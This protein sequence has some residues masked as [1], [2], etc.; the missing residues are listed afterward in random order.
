MTN[1]RLLLKGRETYLHD[2]DG[3]AAKVLR[4]TVF[5]YVTPVVEGCAGRRI[6]L[7]EAVAGTL[8]PSYHYNS[9]DE[10]QGFL[11]VPDNEAEIELVT[12]EDAAS[13]QRD[14]LKLAGVPA[15]ESGFEEC[16]NEQ[17][18]LIVMQ[19]EI[20]FLA[21]NKE[22]STAAQRG[23][24][25][26]F[27]LFHRENHW[28]YSTNTKSDLYNAMYFM[29][30]YMKIDIVPYH[31]L[32]ETCGYSFKAT[33]I[34]RLSHFVIREITLENDW[35]QTDA[36]PVLA[37][38]DRSKKPVVCVPRAPGRYD[39]YGVK[40]SRRKVDAKLAAGF[41]PSAYMIYQPFPNEPLKTRDV[42]KF[43][44]S[45]VYAGDLISYAALALLGSIIGLL[46]PY[47]N[48]LIFDQFIPMSNQAALIEICA[49][50]LAC[51]LGN[52]AFSLVKNLSM[53]RGTRSMEYAV[54]A[55][56]FD[57]LF[58]MPQSFFEQYSSADLVG[59]V[60]GISQIYR[61]VSQ[62]ALTTGLGSLFSILYLVRLFRSSSKLA[63]AAIF[64][65]LFAMAVVAV[66]GTLKLKYE[67]KRLEDETAAATMMYQLLSGIQ[68][69]RLS[70]VENHALY[71]YLKPYIESRRSDMKTGRLEN[72]GATF[73]SAVSI[74]FSMVLYFI[75]I[76]SKVEISIGSFVAFSSAFGM[77]SASMM[78]L[79][80]CYL[81]VNMIIPNYKRVKP[82][83]E[84]TKELVENAAMPRDVTGNIEVS[85]LEF[86]YGK[87]EP[88][89]LKG[90][91]FEIKRGEYVGIVG[92]SGCGKSTLLKCLLGF[93]KPSAG[94]VY[95]DG[96]DVEALDKRE[97]RKHF[98]VVLQDGKLIG[99]SILEN[100]SIANP[101]I[102]RDEVKKIIVDVG[103]EDEI[104]RMPMGLETVLSENTGT[105]SGGQMQRILIGRAIANDPAI[106]FFDEATSALDNV[107]QMK[108]CENLEKRNI[109]RV[110]IAHRLST[111]ENCD[112]ILVMHEGEIVET[113]TFKELMDR[114]GLFYELA[115]RQIV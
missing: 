91:S 50:M 6:F 24:S 27:G 107:T 63:W 2:Q 95:Y 79:V 67:R 56:A 97:L 29:C 110:V 105:I 87:D 43:G 85:N 31:T 100:I 59:R 83:L 74:L 60:I 41:S 75:M 47:L 115:S 98:G 94:K 38:T 61:V 88:M 1:E 57:R 10:A 20:S 78:Q 52:L 19:E 18:Q 32:V 49:V 23:L 103:L 90:I 51:T 34:A 102:S 44:L 55:A 26:I 22:Q 15:E 7:Y 33:D 9:G 12:M 86:S 58:H 3:L 65:V 113:G 62:T 82:L 46:I 14:F 73:S 111:I 11:L 101:R 109:T 35:Y 89:V 71:E 39:A 53:L 92:S 66:I 108:I 45:H 84:G 37:F 21:M 17:Y 112:R 96:Q 48:E 42:A 4:G 69:V 8:I 68:K 25:V 54:Q 16:V 40:L 93:E 70:G 80:N 72:M 30:T 99:G 106:L 5:V 114:K 77:F 81:N 13:V 76:K 28:A 104:R 64:M 36:G